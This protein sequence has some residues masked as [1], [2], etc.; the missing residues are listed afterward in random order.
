MVIHVPSTHIAGVRHGMSR[1]LLSAETDQ[2][3]RSRA[4]SIRVLDRSYGL[5]RESNGI[6]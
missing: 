3:S 1:Q 5:R 4:I 2:R 6:C